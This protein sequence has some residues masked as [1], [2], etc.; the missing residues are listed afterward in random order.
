MY[1]NM[2]QFVAMHSMDTS[3]LAFFGCTKD[4]SVFYFSCVSLSFVGGTS[5]NAANNR[6]NANASWG[7]LNLLRRI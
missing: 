5:I 3:T 2:H 6:V 4:T 7:I 1:N